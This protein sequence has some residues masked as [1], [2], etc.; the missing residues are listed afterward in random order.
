MSCSATGNPS[1]D[2]R[3]TPDG[4]SPPKVRLPKLVQGAGF[5]FFQ[6]HMIGKWIKRYGRIFEINIPFFGRTVMVADPALVKEVWTAGPQL[7]NIEPN[8]GNL[9]GTGTVFALDDQPHRDRRRLLGPALHGQ[10][11]KSYEQMIVDE[12]LREITKWPENKEFR[13]LEPMNRITLNVILRTIFG[14]EEPESEEFREIVR[15]FLKLGSIMAYVPRPPFRTGRY[16]PWGKLDQARAGINRIVFTLIDRAEADPRLEERNDILA[17]LL[18]SRR[19]DGT[20]IPRMDISDELLTLVVAGHESSTAALSWLFE[21]LRRHPDVLAELVREVDEGGSEFRRATIAESLRA[22]TVLDAVGRRV[23]GQNFEL[24]EWRIP[25][26][27]NVLVYLADLHK[28]PEIYPHPERFDPNRFLGTRPAPLTWLPFG[29]GSRRCLGAEFISAEMDIILRTVLHNFHI[30][31][32]AEPDEKMRFRGVARTP[33]LGGLI[34]V[35]RRQT[36]T[37]VWESA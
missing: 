6:H 24:G 10:C 25:R 22:R 5:A 11:L 14:A 31:T 35:H 33:K 30:H 21:R 23:R 34:T 9:V 18:H 32:D 26:D 13:T 36:S 37:A 15:S 19:E 8:I 2:L 4:P 12:T 1:A 29:V 3:Q 28:N 20:A 16:S 17:L 7:V 27:R